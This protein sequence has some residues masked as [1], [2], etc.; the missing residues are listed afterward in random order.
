MNQ[1]SSL[2]NQKIWSVF[3]VDRSTGVALYEV[4]L[5]TNPSKYCAELVLEPNTLSYGLFKLVFG[6]K[7][8][9]MSTPIESFTYVE[10]VPSG[11][12]LS[13]FENAV[14]EITFGLNQTIELRPVLY[15]IDLDALVEMSKLRFYF[16]CRTVDSANLL[17][18]FPTSSGVLADLF[19]IKSGAISVALS[20]INACFDSA[21]QFYFDSDNNAF[22]IEPYGL[23]YA[24]GRQYEFLVRTIY[25]NSIYE[26]RV[27]VMVENALRVPGI[28]LK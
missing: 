21:S 25:L 14:N 8:A 20:N 13:A 27:R 19:G 12:V 17:N 2:S 26:S 15:S 16:Y 10:I 4:D 23:S 5:G 28:N 9:D 7:L 11:L 22:N 6:V 3:A 1:S 24:L 18:P